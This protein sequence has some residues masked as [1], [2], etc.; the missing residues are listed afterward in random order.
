[1]KNYKKFK[2]FIPNSFYIKN[3][4]YK[5]RHRN[6]LISILLI[7]NFL[8]LP[9]NIQKLNTISRKNVKI[10]CYESYSDKGNFK[11]VT[12]INAADKLFNDTFEEVYVNNNCGEALIKDLNILN[13]ISESQVLDVDRVEFIENEK[14]KIGVNINDQ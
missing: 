3:S 5:N 14:Y 13:S 1:M 2:N 9:Y 12:V 6:I 11:L 8:L 7:F 4:K 10:D